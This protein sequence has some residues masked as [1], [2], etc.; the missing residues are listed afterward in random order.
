MSE[1]YQQEI[2]YDQP[3]VWIVLQGTGRITPPEVNKSSSVENSWPVVEFQR[4][5]TLLIPAG[6]NDAHVQLDQ[7]TVWL[8]ITFPQ[9]M[10]EMIA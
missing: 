8:E 6:L 1:G 3:A 9:A 5:Q 10:A 7:D 4:G 2:P